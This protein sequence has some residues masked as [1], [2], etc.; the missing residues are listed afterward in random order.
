MT[1][2]RLAAR[3]QP[4]EFLAAKDGS[5]AHRRFQ[6]RKLR[7]EIGMFAVGRT[8]QTTDRFLETQAR[9]HYRIAQE[10]SAFETLADRFRAR[11]QS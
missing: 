4:I 3:L 2:E 10:D 6:L 5:S 8:I 9:L 11:R 1:H 7:V